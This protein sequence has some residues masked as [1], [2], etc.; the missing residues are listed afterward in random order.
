MTTIN[1]KGRITRRGFFRHGAGALATAGVLAGV[2]AARAARDQGEN[3][4][5]A[6]PE[7]APM[8]G[9]IAMEEH[10]ALSETIDTA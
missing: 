10:F 8:T 4:D 6:K 1:Q 9:K 3:V 5:A 7:S 2:N